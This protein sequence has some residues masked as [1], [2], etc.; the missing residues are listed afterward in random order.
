MRWS[1][2]PAFMSSVAI[3]VGALMVLSLTWDWLRVLSPATS[4]DSTELVMVTPL[5]PPVIPEEPEDRTPPPVITEEPTTVPA[6]P[7]LPSE[8]VTPLKPEPSHLQRL[9]RNRCPGRWSPVRSPC[10]RRNPHGLRNLLRRWRM[11]PCLDHMTP[12]PGETQEISSLALVCPFPTPAKKP[13]QATF[14][15]HPRRRRWR[16]VLSHRWRVGKLVRATSSTGVMSGSSPVLG[17]VAAA[18]LAAEAG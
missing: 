11:R 6:M 1:L 4:L 9:S 18:V 10:Q 17:S 12:Q 14:S 15:A 2:G 13:P 3:H 8:P 5:P 7:P 16:T